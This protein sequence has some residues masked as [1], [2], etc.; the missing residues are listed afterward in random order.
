MNITTD[1]Y[2]T[3]RQIPVSYKGMADNT[4][5][6][7]NTVV[8]NQLVQNGNFAD[9]SVWSVPSQVTFSVSSNIATVT[10]NTNG[11][12]FISQ[13]IP[14]VIGHKYLFSISCWSDN[15]TTNYPQLLI[16]YGSASDTASKQLSTANTW[17]SFNGTFTCV[18]NQYNFIR[19]RNRVTGVTNKFKDL[20]LIDLTQLASSSIT[21]YASFSSLFPLPYYSYNT[22]ELVSFRGTELKTTGK[23]ALDYDDAVGDSGV[24]LVKTDSTIKATYDG[25]SANRYRGFNFYKA[26]YPYANGVFLKAKY[27]LSFDVSNIDT[28]WSF[29]VRAING[30]GFISNKRAIIDTN[31]HYSVEVD[32]TDVNE[33]WYLSASRTGN[34][35][36][37]FEVTFSNIQF[38]LGETET[39][40]TPY[41]TSTLSLPNSTYFPT[42]MKSAGSVYDELTESKAITRIGVVDLGTLTWAVA[43]GGADPSKKRMYSSGLENIAKG[44]TAGAIPP[45][46]LCPK[47]NAITTNQSYGN[48]AV[49]MTF[50]V[51]GLI[52]VNDP[53]YESAVD[54]TAFKAAMNGVYLYYELATPTETDVSLSLT[55]NIEP[56][57]TEEVLPS[58]QYW[59]VDMGTLSWSYVSPR[60]LA[61]LTND[62]KAPSSNGVKGNIYCEKYDVITANDTTT[63]P[64]VK[65][66][67]IDSSSPPFLIVRDADYTDAD[68]FKASVSGT[69]LYFEPTT[70]TPY[71]SPILADIT[72][73]N[74]TDSAVPYRKFWIINAKGERWNLTER[75]L[76]TF[77]NNPQGLGFAKTLSV[78]RYGNT[79]MLI[80]STDNFPNPQG[81]ILFYDSSNKTRYE[82]Y[83]EFVRFLSYFPVTLY[84]QIPAT[85][86]SRIP[87][88]YSLE[89]EVLS[90]T[91]TESKPEHILTAQISLNGLSFYKGDEVIINGT[92][93]TYT[94]ENPS[95]FPVGF[96]ITI[97]GTSMENPYFTLEQ[98][99]SL[100]GEAKFNDTTGFDSVYVN[101]KDGKQNIELQQGGS[102]MPNPLMYQDLS[103]SNGA[104][105]V[106]F[107]K[108]ARG[109]STL[110]IGMDSGSITAVNVKFTPLY[111]SV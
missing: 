103:I 6:K 25:V 18:S 16:F 93:D 65:G 72:Y 77:L 41:T 22:G 89:C 62:T 108:L 54:G 26:S 50:G 1:N 23:N 42:G 43:N 94:I 63:L 36:T 105:Y 48:T 46:L 97:T 19:L 110:T 95:D 33:D 8:F 49:G 3:Y 75:D 44:T 4:S 2:F 7:G 80:D 68:T 88:I 9:T 58:S 51:T 12:Y 27:R 82:R 86:Y 57:G 53:D 84:Y 79:Q 28:G 96:E 24:T 109:T 98:D 78:S 35:T 55:Y 74:T 10:T 76:K 99:N 32:L 56:N 69:Y 39:T 104:I 106:T 64:D 31:G 14:M 71:T 107:V 52:Y 21:D 91:K 13:T 70:K 81:D 17:E 47:Y 92:G 85:Y 15:L 29:G 30:N 90:L 67:A 37:A 11:D 66:I 20:I 73:Y 45:N 34:K 100:Y 102:V 59:A 87:D 40:F 111:R 60:F 101:S 83:N 61:R 38:E 5:I